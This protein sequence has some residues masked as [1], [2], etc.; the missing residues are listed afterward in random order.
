VI[1][2]EPRDRVQIASLGNSRQFALALVVAHMTAQRADRYVTSVMGWPL[3]EEL[4]LCNQCFP[5]GGYSRQSKPTSLALASSFNAKSITTVDMPLT[6][7]QALNSPAGLGF[8]A[9]PV[10]F[11]EALN[12][13]H[14]RG[15][16]LRNC[17]QCR[18]EDDQ[19]NMYVVAV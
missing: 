6:M 18:I 2:A 10:E 15:A 11:I 19:P 16:L 1:A 8:G 12:I 3:S 17:T 13:R 9:E 7:T 5:S 14:L 4:V